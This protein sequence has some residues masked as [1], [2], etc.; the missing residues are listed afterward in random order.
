MPEP[1]SERS[2]YKGAVIR[3]NR[4]FSDC[5]Q[6]TRHGYSLDRPINSTSQPTETPLKSQIP[7]GNLDHPIRVRNDQQIRPPIKQLDFDDGRS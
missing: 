3:N 5:H 7:I 4:D 1:G 6:I 2:D